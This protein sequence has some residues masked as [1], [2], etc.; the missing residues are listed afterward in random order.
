MS[1]RNQ[2]TLTF[3]GERKQLSRTIRGVGED[4][5]QLDRR[6]SRSSDHFADI[7]GKAG[8]GFGLKFSEKIGPILAQAPMSPPLIAAATA[9]IP[10]IGAAVSAGLLMALG[11][12][13]LAAGI[14]SAVK[15]PK[16]GA[17][18]ANL[19]TRA[20]KAFAGFG[21]PFKAPLIRAASTFGATIER[22][23]P[24]LKRMGET[25]AP[26]IDKLAPAFATML[27]KAMPGIEK[28]V[29][30]SVPLFEKL[31][32][33]APKI[34]EA[35]SK[36]F[37]KVA[38]GG[39]GAVKFFDNMLKVATVALP[40]VGSALNQ[41]TGHFNATF[42]IW[43]GIFNGIA[44]GWR[45][46][47]GAAVAAKNVTVGQ[48]NTLVSAIRGIRGRIG[49]AFGGMFDGIKAA[50]RS[51]VN[52]VINRWNSFSIPGVSTPFG[53]IGGFSTPNIPTFHRGGT[54]PGAPGT[55][56]L[57][58]LQA[59][60]KVTPAGGAGERIV[61]EIRSGGSRFEQL[62]VQT[63]ADAI[64]ARGGNVQAVLGS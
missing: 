31:A 51:A 33:H 27:E 19:K 36:F 3:A 57:A 42:A 18:F 52:W 48:V 13:V 16:V 12:G 56:G 40:L 53:Q 5:D 28:A 26:L 62:L 22:I 50:F 23:A 55:E 4:L 63:L 25:M 60:E 38:E 11:G 2:A 35:V 15:D 14:I 20:G 21:E 64:Q 41:L 39:P 47:S 7:G 30:A 54:M 61:I 17:A 8:M 37:S 10:A 59:G 49:G 58:L 24:A 6:V 9:A 32:E 46:I 43:R 34:G 1:N 45:F 29:T 44:A